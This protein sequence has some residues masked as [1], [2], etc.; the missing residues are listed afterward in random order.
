[1]VQGTV[2]FG[3]FCWIGQYIPLHEGHYA[4]AAGTAGVIAAFCR[5]LCL[6]VD[7]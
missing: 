2:I 1:V 4:K 3:V 5:D 6:S 7:D